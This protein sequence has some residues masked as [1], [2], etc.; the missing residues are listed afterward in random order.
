M[1]ETLQLPDIRTANCETYINSIY[2]VIYA[3]NEELRR[4]LKNVPS[5]ENIDTKLAFTAI[6][7]LS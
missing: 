1:Y 7:D 6:A 4:N 3:G 5:G 2:D